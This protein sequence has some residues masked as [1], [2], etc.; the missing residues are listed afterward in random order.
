[1]NQATHEGEYV[2][3]SDGAIWLHPWTGAKPITIRT[4]GN[5]FPRIA[6]IG[7]RYTYFEVSENT[8]NVRHESSWGYRNIDSLARLKNDTILERNL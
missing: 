1:M 3:S 8:Y 7:K 5:R 6:A 4:P 2:T